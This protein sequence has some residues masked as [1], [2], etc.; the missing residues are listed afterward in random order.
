[1][2][3][4][5]I[6]LGIVLVTGLSGCS[7]PHKNMPGTKLRS[8]AHDIPALRPPA[9]PDMIAK[10]QQALEE[11]SGEITLKTAVALALLNNPELK[12]FSWAMRAREAG[13]LQASLRPNTK[14]E[15]N[16]E[17]I[18]GSGTFSGTN[19]AETTIQLSQVIE[20]GA[21]RRART[22]AA[23]RQRDLSGW[24]YEI[25]R[26]DLLTQVSKSFTTVLSA[27]EGLSLIEDVLGIAAQ[28]VETVSARVKAGKA[29]PVEEIKVK[30]AL[31]SL[32]IKVEHAKRTLKI[33]QQH[34]ATTWGSTNP[35]FER[36][37][38][39]L[40][41]VSEMPSQENLAQHL[42]QNPELARWALEISS[43]QAVIAVER[44]KAI[45]NLTLSGGLRR[46]SGPD[47]QVFVLGL[48]FPL[49]LRNRNQGGIMEARYELSEIEAA[50][51]AAEVRIKT[52][53]A[54]VYNTL[55]TAH[56]ALTALKQNVLPGA[57][58]TFDA[59][60]QGYR[61]GKFSLMDVLDAQ[62]TISDA[63]VQHLKAL[64][65]YHLAIADL[66]RLIGG[67]ISGEIKGR[68]Q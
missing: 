5:L 28:V 37:V 35:R 45:P 29:S 54:D 18:A 63:K 34:L 10:I 58:D 41:S 15:I 13:V 55:A 38:G 24:D 17:N 68:M 19:Q 42:A 60:N 61:L 62:R 8:L 25:K 4:K 67:S 32:Q 56:D 16:I 52:A 3:F 20:L 2:R 50:G 1:M 66:E 9:S 65:A 14:I 44:S 22:Q 7:T 12:A 31:A 21:K 6:V 30:V 64:T 59:V 53:L 36:V 40:D 33:S 26:M 46:L 11:P 51:R 49:T 43:R 57:Q 48:S 27:Q 39:Q 47:D 23:T